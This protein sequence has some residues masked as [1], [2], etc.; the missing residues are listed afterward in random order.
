MLFRSVISLGC[1]ELSSVSTLADILAGF[2]KKHEQSLI[3]IM[4]EIPS[5]PTIIKV[6]VDEETVNGAKPKLEYGAVRKR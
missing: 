1:G 2:K 3:G 4:Y 6:T 5:D